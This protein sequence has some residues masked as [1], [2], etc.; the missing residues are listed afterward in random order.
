MWNRNSTCVRRRIRPVL[1]GAGVVALTLLSPATAGDNKAPLPPT[2]L[3]LTSA[4]TGSLSVAWKEPKNNSGGLTGFGLYRDRVRVAT[5][6]TAPRHTFD[7]LACGTTYALAVDS[8]DA[9]GNRSQAI[10][11]SASTSP[12]PQSVDAQPPSAPWGLT[13]TAATESTVALAWNASVDDVGIA[14]Y[15]VLQDGAV[16]GTTSDTA[17]TFANLSCGRSYAFGV[18]AYDAAGNRSAVAAVT[19]S[20]SPCPPVTPPPDTTAPSMPSFLVQTSATGTETTILWNPSTDDVGVTGYTVYR[21]GEKVATTADTTYTFGD[22]A[23]GTSYKLAVDAYDAAGNRSAEASVFASTS[24]CTENEAPATTNPVLSPEA[25]ARVEEASPASNFAASALR[26][27]G[28]SDPDVES[29]LRFSVTGGP[30]VQRAV[31]RLYATSGTA[32]GPA[33][34]TSA[35]DWNESTLSWNNRPGRSAAAVA[36]VGRISAYSWFEYDVTGVVTGDGTYSFVLATTSSDGVDIAARE[37]ASAAQL[38]LYA[39]GGSTPDT[40]PPTAPANVVP[41]ASSTGL[42]LSWTASSDNVGVAGYGVYVDDVRVAS[43]T[44]TTYT[45]AGLAC[46]ASYAVGV[47]AFDAAGNRSARSALTVTTAACPAPPP[48]TAECDKVA[49]PDGSDSGLGT[50]ASPFRTAQQLANSLATGQIGCL[51][52]GTYSGS[53][54]YVLD[55]R[56]SGVTIRSYPGER[57]KLLGIVNV[58][59]GVNGVVLSQLD[60]EGTGSVNTVKIYAAD[61]VVEDSDITNGWRGGS[62]MILGSNSGAGQALRVVVR[63]NRFHECGNPASDN[64]DHSI[65]AS[66]VREGLIENNVFWNHTARA[67]QLYPNANSTRVSH[68]VIYGGPPSIRG[69]IVIGSSTSHTSNNNVVENNVIAYATYWNIY[70]NWEG[71]VG[72]GNV[73]RGNCVWAGASGNIEVDPAVSIADNVVADP[74]FVNMA[75]HDYRLGSGTAC[76]AKVGYDTAALL[77]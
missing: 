13:Q 33:V 42:V 35:S 73:I 67:V 32:D 63:R 68:N 29:Y 10:S 34:Y 55:P 71:A 46:G 72:S 52:G 27:D 47:D 75:A 15:D 77:G 54:G 8:F 18:A 24:P 2:D 23:C 1:A 20:T 45:L 57:A 7:E 62:C 31:L 41:S 50:L 66:N 26:A 6:T 17:F 65:Y 59:N 14:G 43:T 44:S 5:A 11:L 3:E 12:C 58:R 69:G 60:I 4:S 64:K 28:G 61:V 19:A 39:V 53:S 16:T 25:D 37:S 36:D 40:Q 51:R 76:L 30:S 70:T 49:A 38:V 21:D 9:N 48:S 22:L 56:N 74:L